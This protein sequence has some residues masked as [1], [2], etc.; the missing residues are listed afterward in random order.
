MFDLEDYLRLYNWA[1]STAVTAGAL[2]ATSEPILRRLDAVHPKFDHALPAHA[3]TE[4]RE[5][6]FAT[7]R[8]KTLDH[9]EKLFK[10]LNG[11]IS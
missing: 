11:T 8:P 2:P 10:L 1:F 7:V 6:F 3:L 5:E 4:H 9:F